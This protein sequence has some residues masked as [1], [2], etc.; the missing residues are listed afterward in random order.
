MPTIL[1]DQLLSQLTAAL[2][3]A[4][5]AYRAA[6][7]KVAADYGLSQATGLPVLVISRFGDSGVRPGILAE[8]LSLEA[9]SLVR[10]VDHLIESGLLERQE[11]PN[12]RRAK[13][14]RLTDEG[15]KTAT[16]MDQ[17]LTP[18]R[19]KLFGQ[20][21]APDVEACLRVLGGLPAAIANI[22]AT[23]AADD[24]ARQDTAAERKRA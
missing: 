2:T 18:F 6:A 1:P 23:G 22:A 19:R 17:A 12:D 7:D 14:L 11:D 9:S 3:H 5:R 20:F 21:D 4:S 8:T 24:N 15:Q 16:L 10:V 13:I